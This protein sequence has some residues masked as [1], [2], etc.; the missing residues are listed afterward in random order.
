M[1]AIDP[2]AHRELLRRNELA[3]NTNLYWLERY[4]L[5]TSRQ[6]VPINSNIKMLDFMSLRHI[7][8]DYEI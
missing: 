3:S 2:K 5:P 1:P 4:I 6:R 7:E 8:K